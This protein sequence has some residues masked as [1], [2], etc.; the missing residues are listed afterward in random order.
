MNRDRIRRRHPNAFR[1][2]T[3]ED[4]ERLVRR[5]RAGASIERLSEE[6]GRTQRAVCARLDDLRTPKSTCDPLTGVMPLDI[7]HWQRIGE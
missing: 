2:W 4:D 3:L 6:F 1:P 5:H 7:E